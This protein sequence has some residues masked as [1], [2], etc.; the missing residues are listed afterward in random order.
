MSYLNRL[1]LFYKNNLLYKFND[2]AFNSIVHKVKLSKNMFSVDSQDLLFLHGD[3]TNINRGKINVLQKINDEY[4]LLSKKLKNKN[5]KLIVMICPDKYN[6]YS[7]FI[8][9]NK[10]PKSE[11]YE[12]FKNLKK[13][14][15]YIDAYDVLKNQ[16]EKNK[17]DLYFADDTHW[18]PRASKPIAE[19]IYS[20]MNKNGK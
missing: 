17:K 19:R 7:E 14:Y 18:S 6:V 15:I 13:D 12:N 20:N 11:L 4:N 1:K 8:I 16:L 3:V 2:R 5:I 10:Y 9:N